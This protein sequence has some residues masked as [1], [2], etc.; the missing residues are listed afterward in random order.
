M[1]AFLDS[2]IALA[3]MRSTLHFAPEPQIQER[4]RQR[5]S[6]R[7]VAV[8]LQPGYDAA[9]DITALPFPDSSFDFIVCCHVLEH[10]PDD[11]AAMKEIAR[12][13][14]PRGHAVIQVPQDMSMERSD[15]GPELPPEERAIRFGQAD[16][17]RIYGGDLVGRLERAGMAVDE[18]LASSLDGSGIDRWAV[19]DHQALYDC[20]KP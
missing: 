9:L 2:R 3:G 19:P 8:D 11:A 4:L 18:V 17:V 10:I 7:Y 20:T 13:L 5:L 16:H 1:W 6:G 15:E 12:V 14:A